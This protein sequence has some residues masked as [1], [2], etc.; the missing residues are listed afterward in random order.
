M[1]RPTS[2]LNELQML[3]NDPRTPTPRWSC[4]M[5]AAPAG[6]LLHRATP[7]TAAPT[8]G[9]QHHLADGTCLAPHYYRALTSR[10]FFGGLVM[11]PNGSPLCHNICF[12]WSHVSVSP[13]VIPITRTPPP[14]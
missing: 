2:R 14:P 9:W 1:C 13:P 11:A 4:S 10:V 8:C 6:R 12:A 7:T 5:V 3:G